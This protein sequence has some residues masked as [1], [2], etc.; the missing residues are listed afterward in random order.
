[1]T[2]LPQDAVA[3]FSK[4]SEPASSAQDTKSP[5]STHIE[6]AAAEQVNAFDPL[7]LPYKSFQNNFDEHH[8]YDISNA[9]DPNNFTQAASPE[10]KIFTETASTQDA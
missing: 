3:Q 6:N 10:A 1:M 4:P 2:S 7:V 5:E 9:L 8:A